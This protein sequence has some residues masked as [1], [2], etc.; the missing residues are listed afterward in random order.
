MAAA[1]AEFSRLVKVPARAQDFLD[2]IDD[3]GACARA[4]RT[5]NGGR[6]H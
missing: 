3:A 4:D 2:A 5:K 1:R 6:P